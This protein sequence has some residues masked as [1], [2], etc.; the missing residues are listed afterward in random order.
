MN[1]KHPPG[2]TGGEHSS[3]DI[4]LPN[5][6]I[7]E[8]EKIRMIRSQRRAVA[9]IAVDEVLHPEKVRAALWPY[10]HNRRAYIAKP[11]NDGVMR[12]TYMV[13]VF[14]NSHRIEETVEYN[15][16]QAMQMGRAAGF[17][18]GGTLLGASIQRWDWEKGTPID[19]G[20]IKQP[21]NPRVISIR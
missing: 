10:L 16:H 19:T 2:V 21:F 3:E 17:L 7:S 9:R 20:K 15:W 8:F 6:G 4:V 13:G 5:L 12:M 11:D 18:V 1:E 14:P